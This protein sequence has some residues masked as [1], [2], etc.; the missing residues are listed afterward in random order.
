[1]GRAYVDRV[2]HDGLLAEGGAEA[3]RDESGVGWESRLGDQR[4]RFADRL[5]D[6]HELEHVVTG[7]GRDVL[8]EMALRA[9]DL[10]QRMGLGAVVLV[11]LGLL[12]S[13]PVGRRS[14]LEAFRRGRSAAWLP[15]TDW[16][17]LLELPL[18]DVRAL[19]GMGAPPTNRV[20]GSERTSAAA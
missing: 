12:E 11:A 19:L 6:Q 14:I 2:E 10:G 16:E 18:V 7:Y 15:A 13:D 8:G 9:F 5:R 17:S 1:L 20:A 4:T 3:G